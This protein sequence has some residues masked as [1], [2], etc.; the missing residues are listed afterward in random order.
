M[1]LASLV[2]VLGGDLQWTEDAACRLYETD[3]NSKEI[4]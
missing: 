1:S 2:D 4:L 3:P